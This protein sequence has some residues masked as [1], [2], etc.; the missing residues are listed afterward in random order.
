[1]ISISRD[2]KIIRNILPLKSLARRMSMNKNDDEYYLRKLKD[3][4]R[5]WEEE[6]NQVE[7]ELDDTDWESKIDYKKKISDMRILLD[8]ERKKIRKLA[9]SGGKERSKM[10][11][12]IEK[13]ITRIGGS[14][15]Q[16]ETRL[17]NIMIDEQ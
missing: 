8:E 2:W 9:A 15:Q 10:L 4:F 17:N 7:M 13:D 6:L 5:E 1:M 12:D 14:L 16:A 3:Q 11:D